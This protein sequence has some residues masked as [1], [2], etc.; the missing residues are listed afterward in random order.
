MKILLTFF[1]LFFSSSV[2]AETF[3]CTFESN[4]QIY[5]PLFKREGRNFIAIYENDTEIPLLILNETNEY[6]HLYNMELAD[7]SETL[8]AMVLHK[9]NKTFTL[10][11]LKYKETLDSEG[12]CRVFE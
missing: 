6:I 1:V 12:E 4:G 10:I 9:K 11:A 2:F 8:Y 7:F 3:S 5:N